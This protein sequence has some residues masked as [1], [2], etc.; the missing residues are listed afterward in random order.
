MSKKT[1]PTISRYAH[2]LADGTVWGVTKWDGVT[3]YTPPQGHTLHK[4]AADIIV[5][6]GF[7]LLNGEFVDA[8]PEPVE[9]E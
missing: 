3:E 2:V 9:E 7:A 1:E 5:G 8:R 4:V 6:P